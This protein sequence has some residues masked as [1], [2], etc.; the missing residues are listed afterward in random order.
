MS[1]PE[2]ARVST[3]IIALSN[4]ISAR[5]VGTASL[6]PMKTPQEGFQKQGI[7]LKG[8]REGYQ[9]KIETVFKLST[10]QQAVLQSGFQ[11]LVC[12]GGHGSGEVN[13]I[14]H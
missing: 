13:I 8:I 12:F 10:D 3:D 14:E 6:V 2:P 5:Y 7:L 9:R 4:L 1:P 11:N